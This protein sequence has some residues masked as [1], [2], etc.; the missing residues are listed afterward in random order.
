MTTNSVQTETSAPEAYRYRWIALFVIL[1]VEVMDLLDALVTTIAGPVIRTELGGSYSLIQWLGAAY[2]LAMA[3]GLLTGGRLGDIYG[4][5]RMFLIG[6]A[7][8]T[9]ASLACAL[10]P[11]PGA[12][13]GAR[14][15]QGL[16]GAL[17]LPQ[18]L[19][20]LREMFGPAER[21]KAF[22]AFGPV[23]GLASVGGPI[24]AGWLVDADYFGSG[25]RMIFFINLPLGVF[26]VIGALRFLPE[27]RLERAPK[28]DGLGVLFA[29][30]GAF[31][32]LYPLVQGRELDWPVWTF[33]MLAL[34]VLA[35]GL[36]AIYEGRRDKRGL[37]PLVTPSLFRKRAF[38]GGLALGLMFFASLIG[39]GLVFTFYLQIGLGYTPLKAGLTTL[40][41]ALGMVAG[42][43]VAGAGLAEKL[44][45]KLLQLGTLVM[46]LGTVVFVATVH[47][48]GA[49]I[50]PWHLIPAL[51]LLGIGMGLAMAPF[52]GIVLAGVDD[53]ESGSASGA[54]TSVQQ[55][56]GAFGIAVLGTIFF[57]LL[58][59]AVGHHVDTS[60]DALRATLTSAG[61]PAEAQP[62]VVSGLRAC[63]TDRVA[64]VNPDVTPPSCRAQ[65]SSGPDLSGYVGEQVRAGFEDTTVRTSGV[66][67]LL[68]LSAFGL[69]F[70]MP[71]QGKPESDH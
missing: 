39:T 45:R 64:E 67:V 21:A 19:G 11:S 15:V 40:P 17:M 5:R 3:I 25:W 12:L 63:L 66:S 38:T 48:A 8:F 56:G 22:G 10:A 34:G 27:S 51:L 28:L 14:A 16:F 29:A 61:V 54:I 49:G 4:R 62:A 7:G 46:I 60:A 59:G 70:L 23:M 58:P 50:T 43:I 37:D 6:A 13:V 55:L 68:L 53:E 9:L 47:W 20:M 65:S 31:L 1:A 36:F 69:T 42:F 30:G 44:G 41:Q 2:T 35:F 52:F 26:A 57:A 71:R 24:L 32:L 18:G 33:G